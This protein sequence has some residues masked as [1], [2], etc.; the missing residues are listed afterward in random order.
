MV[1]KPRSLSAL[2]RGNVFSIPVRVYYEDTDVGAVV[3]YANYLR[4][5]E[6]AAATGCARPGSSWT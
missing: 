1:T 3:Y 6:R 4:F 2:P 5:I